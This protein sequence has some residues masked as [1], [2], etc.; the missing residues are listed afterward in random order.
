MSLD[1]RH[2]RFLVL[3]SLEARRATHR[4]RLGVVIVKSGRILGKGFNRTMHFKHAEEM[5]LNENWKSEYEGATCYVVR[6]RR[7]RP[8]GMA[9]PCPHCW[10]ALKNAG[11]DKVIYSTSDLDFPIRMEQII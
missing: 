8:L 2:A 5:A 6:L 11:I 10:Q 1:G 4:H 9:R 7:D 3:A